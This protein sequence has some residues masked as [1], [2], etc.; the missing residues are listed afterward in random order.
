MFVVEWPGGIRTAQHTC[1][2]V[3]AVGALGFEPSC[4]ERPI[5]SDPAAALSFARA[6]YPGSLLEHG[7][8]VISRTSFQAAPRDVLARLGPFIA[9]L[10]IPRIASTIT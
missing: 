3:V 4:W 6:F 7:I 2:H 10:S 8:D 5:Q 9:V 1:L